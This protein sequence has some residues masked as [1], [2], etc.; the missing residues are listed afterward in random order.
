[1]HSTCAWKCKKET[2]MT[3]VKLLENLVCFAMQICHMT[4]HSVKSVVNFCTGS[5][6]HL[7]MKTSN[8]KEWKVV[9]TI[10]AMYKYALCAL[11]PCKQDHYNVQSLSSCNRCIHFSKEFCFCLFFS[12]TYLL[13]NDGRDYQK[14]KQNSSI[15]LIWCNTLKCVQD[16]LM[17]GHNTNWHWKWQEYVA[18]F[19]KNWWQERRAAIPT[20]GMR[21]NCKLLALVQELNEHSRSG[22]FNNFSRILPLPQHQTK[23]LHNICTS[24]MVQ[25]CSSSIMPNHCD[26]FSSLRYLTVLTIFTRHNLCRKLLLL[27][28]EA[29]SF[30]KHCP[31]TAHNVPYTRQGAESMIDLCA[32]QGQCPNEKFEV[33]VRTA[34]PDDMFHTMLQQ[35]AGRPHTR[36]PGRHR[37]HFRP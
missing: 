23:A 32:V 34:M 27:H 21:E 26:K 28:I 36:T 29:V 15:L 7:C 2:S 24:A 19:R 35:G 25:C 9:F 6:K 13:L 5:A 8:E 11:L 14:A 30:C 4:S 37:F 17:M 20:C 12:R 31:V 10:G 16:D 1:M 18:I 22:R 3:C 33:A